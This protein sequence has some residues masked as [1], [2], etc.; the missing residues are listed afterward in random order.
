[1]EGRSTYAPE[2]YTAMCMDAYA[3]VRDC[4]NEGK[5]LIEVEFP[6]IPGEDADYKAASDVYIDANVQ[7][8]LVVA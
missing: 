2:S 7:Y 6:A 3:S 5:T 8:A 4:L 1:M